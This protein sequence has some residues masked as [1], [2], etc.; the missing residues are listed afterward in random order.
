MTVPGFEIRTPCYR[1]LR[2]M[3]WKTEWRFDSRNRQYFLLSTA[4][5]PALKPIKPPSIRYW[6]NFSRDETAIAR[7]ADHSYPVQKVSNEWETRFYSFTPL[8]ST[9]LN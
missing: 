8:H 1:I 7:E 2:D 4:V 6:G 9:V 5:T 3:G